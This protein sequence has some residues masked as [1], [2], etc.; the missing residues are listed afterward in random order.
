MR[1]YETHHVDGNR[2]YRFVRI[3]RLAHWVN[4]ASFFVL[5][6]SGLI[7]FLRHKLNLSADL[8]LQIHQWHVYIGA[9]YFFGPALVF[10][11]GSWR[12]GL[13][14]VGGAF[15]WG[16]SEIL[17]LLGPLRK[18]LFPKIPAP[19]V[20]RF[21]AGQRLNMLLQFCGKWG[22][23]VTGIMMHLYS[24]QLLLYNIHMILFVFLTILVM[25]HIYMGLFHPS[26]RH[27]LFAILTGF[28]DLDWLEQHHPGWLASLPAIDSSSNRRGFSPATPGENPETAKEFASSENEEIAPDDQ[29]LKREES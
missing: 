21:N 24:G 13:R 18:T 1:G 27:S 3:E 29:T 7:L 25:G 14:W 4:A 15:R 19:V 26:T 5:A 17:W 9:V 8:V 28:V 11:I 6:V 23:A 12:D 20:G 16:Y 10:L 2:V 22:M